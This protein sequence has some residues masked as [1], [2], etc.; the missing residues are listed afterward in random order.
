MNVVVVGGGKVGQLLTQLLVEE[1]HNVVVIDNRESVLEELQESFDVAIV[2]GNGATVDIQREANVQECDLMIAA[3][4]SD[5]INLLW[6]G[7]FLS[8][9]YF[10]GE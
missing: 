10:K 4:S 7:W 1:D 6:T 9:K 3:T 5:E 8:K 2:H